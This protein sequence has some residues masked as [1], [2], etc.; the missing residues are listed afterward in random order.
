MP[1]Y[2]LCPICRNPVPQGQPCPNCAGEAQPNA[3]AY[4]PP[5]PVQPPAAAVPDA[6]FFQPESARY[7]S[8]EYRRLMQKTYAPMGAWSI[9]FTLLLFSVPVVGFL[10]ALIFACG[11]CAKKQ[12]TA[13]ARA[14]LLLTLFGVLFVVL[15]VVLAL[16]FGE[17][18]Y[19]SAGVAPSFPGVF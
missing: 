7:D 17:V 13:L 16:V 2:I 6:A 15:L 11:G 5:A 4:V 1:D 9:F 3:G 18:A 8:E 10:F 19:F 12:K 14:Y